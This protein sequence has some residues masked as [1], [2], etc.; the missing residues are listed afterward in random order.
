M[1]KG[2]KFNQNPWLEPHT[3]MNTD[4]RKEEKTDFE[5]SIT[6]IHLVQSYTN[7]VNLKNLYH[8]TFFQLIFDL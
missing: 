5:S 1:Y 8:K 3:D 6:Q 7:K 2:I 4:L